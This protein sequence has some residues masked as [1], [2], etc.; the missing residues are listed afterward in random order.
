MPHPDPGDP[1]TMK[2]GVQK[3]FAM[4]TP[5]PDPELLAEFKRFVKD[6]VHSNLTPLSP[7]SDLSV[8]TWLESCNYPK[9]R[10]NQLLM[11][12][13]K[14]VDRRDPKYALV[15]SFMKDE[16]YPEYKHARAI[17][18]RTD[19]FKTLVGP[20]FRLIEKELFQL[21]WFIKKIPVADRPKYL[22]DKIGWGSKF[23]A[24]D[25]TAYEAHFTAEIMESCEFV[26]Y[27]YM[28]SKLP[29]AY[30]EEFSH[31]LRVI[32][33]RNRCVF[34][35]F[36]MEINAKR[37]SGEMNTSL[38]NGFSNLMLMLFACSKAGCTDVNGCVEGDDGLFTMV[39][40]PP[41]SEFFARLGM[42]I[43]MEVSDRLETASFCGL[44][45][46]PI[47][48][49]NVTNPLEELVTFGLTSSTY[50]RSRSRRKMELLRCKAISMAY[51]YGGCPILTSLARYGLRVTRGYSAVLSG[52]EC[53]W[54][55]DQFMEAKMNSR[56]KMRAPPL[57]TRLLV[58]ELYHIP[59]EHQIAIER[60]LDG[61][62]VLEPICHPLIDLHVPSVWRDY[63][64][65][66]FSYSDSVE[67]C[68]QNFVRIHQPAL[69]T[70]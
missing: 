8:N 48:L 32:A 2:A 28:T 40:T 30:A 37:M 4:C 66:Y 44:V 9:W 54:V 41:T 46:D 51:Q 45:F 69:Q 50:A 14:I 3:R 6:W 24:T 20:I 60:Y 34:K 63:H 33:G 25:H 36:D 31:N 19:E 11:K 42:T 21:H 38:G 64:D 62:A 52:H 17:N 5:T 27:D 43:K 10:K 65:R 18:S 23:I 16:C 1:D 47:D 7:T 29:K 57:R 67:H 12:H 58:E 15:K 53:Q 39:G 55:R 22:A 61:L 49:I 35:F 59:V 68:V 26:L 13:N 70:G 56:G